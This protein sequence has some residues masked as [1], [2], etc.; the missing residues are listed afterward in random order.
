MHGPATILLGLV[1]FAF[2][3]PL[4]LSKSSYYTPLASDECT[5]ESLTSNASFSMPVFKDRNWASE[6]V[7]HLERF[8][9]PGEGNL[10][11]RYPSEITDERIGNIAS[12]SGFQISDDVRS[13][14]IPQTESSHDNLS[15]SLMLVFLL[16]VGVAAL[17]VF[18][19]TKDLNEWFIQ[20]FSVD[21]HSWPDAQQLRNFRT[22]GQQSKM[23]LFKGI[24]FCVCLVCVHSAC[25][26]I[27]DDIRNGVLSLPGYGCIE[28]DP[29]QSMFS[30][31]CSFDWPS[32][33]EDKCIALHAG[34]IFEGN[35]H[36]IDL[37]GFTNWE[38]LVRIEI[39]SGPR[40]LNSDVNVPIGTP[41]I[42]NVHMINGQT[43][44]TGGFIVQ[45]EQQLFVVDS[46]SSTGIIRG[47]EG[48]FM[49]NNAVGGGGIC[50]HKCFG[51]VVIMNCWSTGEIQGYH[52][53][54]IAGRMFGNGDAIGAATITNC[55]STGDITG[56]ESG[57]ITGSFIGHT[58]NVYITRSSSTGKILGS[59]SGGICGSSIF[60]VTIEKCYSSGEISGRSTGGITGRGTGTVTIRNCYSSGHITAEFDVE[61]G[62]ICGYNTAGD[63]TIENSYASGDIVTSKAG[64]IIGGLLSG[65]STIKN[66]VYNGQMPI[67]F[68][69]HGAYTEENNSGDLNDITGQIYCYNDTL[70]DRKCWDTETVWQVVESD[71]P[72]FMDPIMP[73]PSSSATPTATGTPVAVEPTGSLTAAETP[74]TVASPSLQGG[75]EGKREN[76]QSGSGNLEIIIGLCL[77]GV[78]CVILTFIGYKRLQNKR[79]QA[80]QSKTLVDLYAVQFGV[81]EAAKPLS[82]TGLQR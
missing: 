40:S 36:Q 44:I 57:G 50:G 30:V 10:F 71:F 49:Q 15:G 69:N 25:I 7:F 24:W 2:S 59:G 56:V 42:R 70:G 77:V 45:S 11:V 23:W 18:L 34:E 5:P 37:S 73:I 52:A 3:G 8:S 33:D 51:E 21:V 28:Y 74:T 20:R 80:E 78:F 17:S 81:S 54:G 63:V 79:N 66:C 27:G 72:V 55:H 48:N 68:T 6:G 62:G 22:V 19:P 1:V 43:S 65:V 39:A 38:G 13:S 29:T 41:V 16:T 32:G 67:V 82:K 75:D 12:G 9:N 14:Q 64:G 76:Q 47:F 26:D 58:S 60:S 46:C 4:T 61:S 31:Q 35:G 53:G